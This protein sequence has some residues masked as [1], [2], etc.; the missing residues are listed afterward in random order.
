MTAVL[1][2]LRHRAQRVE[3]QFGGH[4]HESSKRSI[5]EIEIH[6][7]CPG[8]ETAPGFFMSA[9]AA[10]EQ[11]FHMLESE[12]PEDRGKPDDAPED[13]PAAS[14]LPVLFPV[15][16]RRTGDPL[17]HRQTPAG[18]IEDWARQAFF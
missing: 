14:P 15:D 8:R 9:I 6:E 13:C 11:R 12:S 3:F 4:L 10:F 16:Y 7:V 18:A 1:R 17:R 2:A 5:R